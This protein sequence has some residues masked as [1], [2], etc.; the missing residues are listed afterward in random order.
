MKTMRLRDRMTLWFSLM[1]FFIAAIF[2]AAVYMI[3]EQVLDRMLQRD[4]ELSLAQIVA[5]VENEDGQLYFED[6]VPVTLG[7]VYFITEENGSELFSRGAD[8][9]LFDDIS[10][11]PGN[12]RKVE[13]DGGHWL[14]LDS[15]LFNEDEL[16][17]RVRVGISYASNEQVLAALRLILFIA[18]PVLLAISV[19]GGRLI[20]TRSLRPIREVIRSAETIAGGD[21]AARVPPAPA[22]DELGEMTD[23]LNHMLDSVE[24]AFIR[25]K[26]F[27]SDASHELRTPVSILRAYVETLLQDETLA[28]EQKTALQTMV[29]E[30]DKMQKLIRQ[31]LMIARGQEGSY[32]VTIEEVA[33][34]PLCAGIQDVM[35]DS[36]EEKGI[37]LELDVPETLTV[38]A[39]QSLLTELVLNL[40]ENAVKYGR[41]Q[42][43][44][45]IRA[46]MEDKGVKLSITD[47]GIGIPEDALPHIFER[48]YRV[49]EARDRSGTGLG[50]SIC[51]WIVRAHG[52]SISAT[53][54]QGKGTRMDVFL[55]FHS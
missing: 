18:L 9:T 3:T 50:L 2:S 17:I 31:L 37:K 33:L 53:S 29:L 20:A 5:Q 10:L 34:R 42:G 26:R 11:D 21:L 51:E 19:L 12:I 30:C 55:P 54:T 43:H 52:G 45:Q 22:R 35:D 24:E 1:T 25:E 16:S 46:A 28:A 27:A 44:I 49:D 7:A 13:K 47:D 15:Q 39:D 38:R 4:L 32:P 36:L 41:E 6:E 8:I 40:V 48:F 14:L 23:T